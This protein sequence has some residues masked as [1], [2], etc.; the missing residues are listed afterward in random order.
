MH[1]MLKIKQEVPVKGTLVAHTL[2]T[3]QVLLVFNTM[4]HTAQV[5]P[6]PATLMPV[7]LTMITALLPI[8]IAIIAAVLPATLHFYVYFAQYQA[9]YLNYTSGLFLQPQTA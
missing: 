1:I 2:A 6:A 8:T 7:H 5:A 4:Q 3:L 9:L